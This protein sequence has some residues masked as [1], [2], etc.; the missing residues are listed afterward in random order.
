M[1]CLPKLHLLLSA[2][3]IHETQTSSSKFK[4][5]TISLFVEFYQ[6]QQILEKVIQVIR[7]L[8]KRQY[9]YI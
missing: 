6:R 2:A 8:V 4:Q 1:H 5:Q 7:Y 9:M 3:R